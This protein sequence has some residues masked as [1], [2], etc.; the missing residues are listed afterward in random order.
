MISRAN[1]VLVKKEKKKVRVKGLARERKQELGLLLSTESFYLVSFTLM[2]H[3]FN[4]Y[5]FIICSDISFSLMDFFL[6][7]F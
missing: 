2:S 5:Y 3:N 4:Y 1:N 6:D 7:F